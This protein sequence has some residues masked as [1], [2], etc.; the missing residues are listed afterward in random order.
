[1][2]SGSR[3]SR[4]GYILGMATDIDPKNPVYELRKFDA[5][6]QFQ[7]IIRTC[8]TPTPGRRVGTAATR[9]TAGTVGVPWGYGRSDAA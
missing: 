6:F 2:Y 7:K 9:L 4:M 5:D 1:M 3:F 8:P